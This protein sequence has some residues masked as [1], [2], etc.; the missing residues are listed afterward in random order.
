MNPDDTALLVI[1]VQERLAP[2]VGDSERMVW[3]CGRLLR[4]AAALGVATAATE[5]YPEK[6][7]PTVPELAEQLTGASPKRMF[8]CRECDGLLDAWQAAGRH[9]VLLAGIETHV[10]VQQTALDLL[11]AGFRV[12]LAVDAAG[13]RNPLDHQTALQRM[14]AAGV[15]PTTTEAALFEWCVDS[16]AD[17]FKAISGLAKESAPT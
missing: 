11:S 3:N 15:T 5:Q 13:S 7:G 6:L 1:D 14:T 17:A 8:S 9:R 12:Y 4:G 2:V 16:T 10:C